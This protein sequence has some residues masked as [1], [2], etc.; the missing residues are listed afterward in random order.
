MRSADASNLSDALSDKSRQANP[1]RLRAACCTGTKSRRTTI[2]R[3]RRRMLTIAARWPMEESMA[4]L[5]RA[6]GDLRI[7]MGSATY[8]HA[9]A[10][11]S[12][13]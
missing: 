13:Q 1:D 10:A 9:A 5:P 6:S 3:P 12:V 2:P 8:G 4:P 7:V 11:Y